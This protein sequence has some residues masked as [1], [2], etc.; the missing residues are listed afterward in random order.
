MAALAALIIYL[1]P[2]PPLPV[3][4]V[5][6]TVFAIMSVMDICQQ[7]NTIM[8]VLPVVRKAVDENHDTHGS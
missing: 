7:L 3:S 5:A 8:F 6:P 4:V 1:E 2:P